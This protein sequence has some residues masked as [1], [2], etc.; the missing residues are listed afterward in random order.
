MEITEVATPYIVGDLV[1]NPGGYVIK[2]ITS[3]ASGPVVESDWEPWIIRADYVKANISME[4]PFITG[5]VITGGTITGATLQTAASSLRVAISSAVRGAVQFF[6]DVAA[7]GVERLNGQLISI[8]NAFP[9]SFSRGLKLEA[10]ADSGQALAVVEE[11]WTDVL[12]KANRVF[13]VAK[14]LSSAAE[15]DLT[16]YENSDTSYAYL[17]AGGHFINIS[18]DTGVQTNSFESGQVTVAT[19]PNVLAQ[20]WVPFTRTY[21][22][23][24]PAVVCTPRASV[25]DQLHVSVT[26]V[27]TSGFN[28]YVKTT[29][30]SATVM[31]MATTM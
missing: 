10:I 21:F 3:R 24:A 31:W 17:R 12:G 8:D 25:P 23:V 11:L 5:G 18:S 13:A 22:G 2:C 27:T 20:Q 4:S 26:G 7:W 14:R 19:T 15:L 29:A 16:S 6:G 1:R 30:S 28:L 9:T